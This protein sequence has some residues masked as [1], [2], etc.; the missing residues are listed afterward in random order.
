MRQTEH[1]EPSWVPWE[2]TLGVPGQDSRLVLIHGNTKVSVAARDD[3]SLN[4]FE[5]LVYSGFVVY[6]PA[7][8]L[9][10][11]LDDEGWDVIWILLRV[12]RANRVESSVSP[13]IRILD[14]LVIIIRL[15]ALGLRLVVLI[16][17]VSESVTQVHKL[18]VLRY[19]RDLTNELDIEMDARA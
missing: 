7:L 9:S 5:S 14:H 4:G 10:R 1:V 13:L 8:S 12:E 19:T 6:A 15:L 16:V 2:P 11:N 18:V 3:Q 17:R